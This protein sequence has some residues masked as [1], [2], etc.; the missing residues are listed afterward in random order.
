MHSYHVDAL[1]AELRTLFPEL[2]RSPRNYGKWFGL[3]LSLRAEKDSVHRLEQNVVI[4]G[5]RSKPETMRLGIS[6]SFMIP[7]EWFTKQNRKLLKKCAR[8]L[9]GSGVEVSSLGYS[10]SVKI[11]NYDERPNVFAVLSTSQ[12]TEELARELIE[13]LRANLN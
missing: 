1:T 12:R 6:T 8:E 3:Q 4:V 5:N 9:K 13:K 2:K 11:S 10:V 7:G